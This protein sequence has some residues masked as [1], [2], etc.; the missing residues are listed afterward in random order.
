MTRRP[1]RRCSDGT[2]EES[3]PRPLG[4]IARRPND[5]GC[6]GH[7]SCNTTRRRW[8]RPCSGSRRSLHRSFHRT[9]ITM[10]AELSQLFRTKREGVGVRARRSGAGISARSMSQYY[11]V[12]GGF[13][14]PDE[15]RRRPL[16]V[17]A[18]NWAATAALVASFEPD[19]I[20][21]DTGTTSTDIIPDRGWPR[22]CHR[23][24]RSR[25]D[26]RVGSWSTLARFA[27]PPKRW[28][29]EVPTPRRPGGRLRRRV[30]HHRRRPPLARPAAPG[31]LHLADP[32][33]PASPRGNSRASGSRAWSARTVRCS[34]RRRSMESPASL[35][36]AQLVRLGGRPREGPRAVALRSRSPSLP[37][38]ETSS[39]PRRRNVPGLRWWRSRNRLGGASRH[40]TRRRRCMAVRDGAKLRDDGVT[41]RHRLTVVKIGGGLVRIPGAFDLVCSAIAGG[42][43]SSRHRRRARRGA[44]RGRGSRLRP[45]PE[46]VPRRR[47]LD[48]DCW[49]WISMPMCSWSGS[50]ERHWSRRRGRW[51]P[52]WTR[53]EWS[54]WRRRAGCGP[55]MCCP[56]PGRRRATASRRSSRARSMRNTWCW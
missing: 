18:S 35:V 41:A 13:L 19:A 33:R 11:T 28:L 24:H 29:H 7:S 17:A 42:G 32:G 8:C 37:A 34:T 22:S 3:T 48:G 20:L 46:T 27:R 25:R 53:W 56:T 50:R 6:A 2:S 31:R 47:S 26:S 43:A 14:Q 51:R 21:I 49:P 16:E 44:V 30:R 4:W 12:S 36:E 15:A 1:A 9:A 45:R 40:G 23:A 5:C 52:R 54:S 38:W 39:R 10:T 55:R